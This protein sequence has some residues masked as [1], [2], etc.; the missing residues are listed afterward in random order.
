[1]PS[2]FMYVQSI[3]LVQSGARVEIRAADA[4]HAGSSQICMPD[5]A[6]VIAFL[7]QVNSQC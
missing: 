2:G 1:M 7:L 6:A 4:W 3:K 5:A